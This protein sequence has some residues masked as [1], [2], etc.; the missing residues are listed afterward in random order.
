MWKI[1]YKLL[2]T[3]SV[4]LFVGEPSQNF[5][6]AEGMSELYTPKIKRFPAI[7]VTEL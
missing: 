7:F 2:E 4:A 3:S 1:K 5:G 6:C